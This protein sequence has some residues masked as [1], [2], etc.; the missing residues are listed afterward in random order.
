METTAPQVTFQESAFYRE[1]GYLVVEQSFSPDEVARYRDHFMTLRHASRYPGDRVADTLLNDAEDPLNR[2]PRMINMH[3]WDRLSLEWMNDPRLLDR[4]EALLGEPTVGMQTMIYFKPPGA[5]G[6]AIHQDNFYLKIHPGTCM[7]A[8]L[9]LDDSDEENGCLKVVPGS[10]TWQILCHE[11]ADY[12]RSFTDVTAPLPEGM[13]PVSIPM[14]AGDVIF[15]NGSLVHGSEPNVSADRFRRSL[16]AHYRPSA[17]VAG[18]VSEGCG[19]WVERD[20]TPA[21]EIRGSL[22]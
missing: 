1:H 17:S 10:G 8:W 16:I 3:T 18:Q 13:E 15:F 19:V 4:V 14:T 5:R 20:G 7:A 11:K 9:A 21:I 12:T 2:Y 22:A 6:Q